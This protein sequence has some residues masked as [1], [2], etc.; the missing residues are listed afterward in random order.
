ME[1]K[2]F[3]QKEAQKMYRTGG[4]EILLVSYP[5]IKGET[6]LAQHCRAMVEALVAYA[7][8]E[9]LIMAGDALSKAVKD[10]RLFSFSR[11]SFH[12]SLDTVLEKRGIV[13]TLQA[14]L[15]EGQRT[16]FTRALA[17]LWEENRQLQKKFPRQR[18]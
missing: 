18:L 1:N 9:P 15:Y 7:E 11:Y 13:C 5:E 14:C 4:M 10:H 16:V 8:G 6:P 3:F 12:I 17:T 2:L